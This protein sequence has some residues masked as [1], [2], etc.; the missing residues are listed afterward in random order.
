MQ[1]KNQPPCP[2]VGVPDIIKILTPS[3]PYRCLVPP[4]PN[5]PSLKNWCEMRLG[6]QK[7]LRFWLWIALPIWFS[8]FQ[9][10]LTFAQPPLSA[11]IDSLVE[12]DFDFLTSPRESDGLLLRRLSLDLRMVVP[13]AAELDEFQADAAPDRWSRWVQ[14]FLDDPL[15]RE[16]IVEW[17]D[18]TL[19]QRRPNKHVDRVKWLAYLRQSVDERKPIDKVVKE[20]VSSTWWNSTQR[21]QQ[22]FFLDRDGDPH[23]VVRDMGRIFFGRD[24]QCA[25]CHDHPQVNDY[26]QIDY[27]GLLAFVSPSSL[28]E[29][30]FKDDKGAEQKLQIYSER[31]AGDAPFE[32]VFDKGVLFRSGTRIPGST[33]QFEPYLA[34]DQRYRPEAMPDTLEGAPKPPAISRRDALVNQLA[35]GNQ[36]FAENWANRVWALMLGRGLVHP[37]DMHHPDNPPSNPK[38]MNALTQSLVASGFDL[39]AMIQQIAMSET[40]QRGSRLPIEASLVHGTVLRLPAEQMQSMATQLQTRRQSLDASLPEL[41]SQ[42]EAA[43]KRKDEAADAWRAVQK[44]RV[45]VRADLDKAEAAFNEAMKK[46]D[47]ANVASSKATKQRDD[48]KSRIALLNEATAKIEQAKALVPGEDAEIA[49][50]IAITKAKSDATSASL[51]ALDQGVVDSAAARDAQSVALEAE[52]TK[53]MEVVARLQPIEQSLHAADTAFLSAR[54]EWQKA[55]AEHTLAVNKIVSINH[56][57]KWLELSQ[58]LAQSETEYSL[59][60]QTRDQQKVVVANHAAALAAHQQKI[61]EASTVLNGMQT[62][63][64]AAQEMLT[65]VKGELA[66][67]QNSQQSLNQSESLVTAESLATAKQAII[68]AIDARHVMLT[69]LQ[70]NVGTTE[71]ELAAQAA[72]IANLTTE[73]TSLDAQNTT[74]TQ[75]LKHL[76][77]QVELKAGAIQQTIE[78]CGTALQV[79]FED[80]Q[81]S[82]HLAMMRSLSPEQMGLSVLQSTSVLGNFITNE[83][84]ELEKQGPLPPDATAEQKNARKMQATRQAIDKL[85]GNVDVFSN[86]YASGVGQTSDEF[87]ASPDQALYMANGGSV[88]QWSAVSGNNVT[89][90]VVQQPDAN[91]AAVLMYRSLLSREPVDTE[92]QWAAEQLVKTP[93]KKAAIAQELVWGL[94]TSSEFRVY[95]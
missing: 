15:H 1:P 50:A 67:L 9:L 30:K 79:V 93:D 62:K 14:R 91:A 27:H 31:A 55:Q 59:A 81:K 11:T 86:L 88:F 51:A 87:F 45:V 28:V 54:G 72:L 8:A 39:R 4:I 6:T 77:E 80:R 64:N 95:P 20:V 47:A 61:A 58:N 65:N 78:T 90:Q 46:L 76:D 2:P 83:L 92:R 29:A 25:Q 94:I 26:L 7:L 13:T 53:T 37:L 12:P 70:A 71:T 41:A 49:S 36:A 84:A 34:P 69:T 17:L 42:A 85:R 19:M 21:A 32:S 52:R 89:A 10:P 24:M 44:E 35:A 16:R 5:N 66:V 57:V 60:M 74:L 82:G 3:L 75:L 22:R 38:L 18:K 48:A 43:L 63:R 56:L 33:E 73:Q 40:Y 23:A 68:A